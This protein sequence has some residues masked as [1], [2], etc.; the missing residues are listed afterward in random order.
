MFKT[1]PFTPYLAKVSQVFDELG[2]VG[3]YLDDDEMVIVVLKGL[4]KPWD[5][6]LCGIVE[7]ENFLD[8]EILWDDFM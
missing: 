4:F 8:W 2:V 5:N 1:I 6:F 3:E 7:R